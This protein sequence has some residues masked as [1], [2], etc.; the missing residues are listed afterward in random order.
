MKRGQIVWPCYD[1]KLGR[2]VP[3][4]VVRTNQHNMVLVRFS[5]WID[6]DNKVLDV[7]FRRRAN[8]QDADSSKLGHNKVRLFGQ[9]YDFNAW[10]REDETMNM[11]IGGNQGSYYSLCTDSD[12]FRY[13]DRGFRATQ[14]LKIQSLQATI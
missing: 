6:D 11:F 14:D 10:V 2:A 12:L 8:T 9:R 4:I 3:G 5:P 1:G 7:W 13:I